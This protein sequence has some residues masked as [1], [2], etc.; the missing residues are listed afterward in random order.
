MFLLRQLKLH[1]FV[2]FKARLYGV[3]DTFIHKTRQNQRFNLKKR[4]IVLN[5]TQGKSQRL[6]PGLISEEPF[7][8]RDFIDITNVL[9]KRQ[10]TD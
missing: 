2:L 5:V 3:L 10:L 9:K 8:Q 1:C 6:S 4:W 7:Y